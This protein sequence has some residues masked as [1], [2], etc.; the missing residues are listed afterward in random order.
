MSELT[1]L[2]RQSKEN[3]SRI[4]DTYKISINAAKKLTALSLDATLFNGHIDLKNFCSLERL[5]V[6][7]PFYKNFTV[8]SGITSLDL[9]GNKDFEEVYFAANT[10]PNLNLINLAHSNQIYAFCA[11]DDINTLERFADGKKEA[12]CR[13]MMS[14]ISAASDKRMKDLLES[15]LKNYLHISK[16]HRQEDMDYQ[17]F[18]NQQFLKEYGQNVFA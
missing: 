12:F 7:R 13:N 8:F 6:F 1:L 16:F 9:S 3:V 5:Y 17:A 11:D 18:L 14:K 4:F 10:V 15:L 2:E